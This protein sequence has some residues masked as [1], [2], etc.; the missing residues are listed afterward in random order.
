M[1]FAFVRDHRRELIW[2]AASVLLVVAAFWAAFQFVQPSPPRRIVIAAASKGSPYYQLAEQYQ[3]VVKDR[4]GIVLDI[5]ETDGSAENLRLLADKASG[6]SLGFVQGGISNVNEA[7]HLRSLGRLFYEPLWVFY[8]GDAPIDRLTALAGKRV[9]VGPAGGGTNQ[10]ALKLLAANGVT[11]STATLI[12]ME[13]PGY[14]EALSIGGA[15]AGFLVLGPE[16][17]T[18]ARLFNAPNVHLMN[19]VQADAYVQR[20]PFLSRLELKQGVVDFARN[21]PPADTAMVAT[22]AALLARAD[23][24][25]TVVDLMAQTLVDVH[26]RPVVGPDGRAPLFSR[27]AEFPMASDPEYP[28]SSDA[29]RVYKSGPTFLQRVLPF[30]IAI[31]LNRLVLLAIP[32]VGLMLPLMR[33]GPMLY[34]FSQRRRITRWYARL[35]QVE[36]SLHPGSPASEFARASAEIDAIEAAV[37]K[38]SVPTGFSSQVYDLR[39]HINVVRGHLAAMQGGKDDAVRDA[40]GAR[41]AAARS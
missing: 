21:L 16:A 22:K 38:M 20:F 5:R 27:S 29:T 11:A 6:V 26:A 4:S 17:M 36:S 37:D 24:Q 19:L 34:N 3:K 41:P 1:T 35:R 32:L 13:L 33:F 7:P 8:R 14:V 15:D 23:V 31:Q 39:L 25:P 12:N 10:L 2:T 40:V 9:L 28:M 30:W 18:I